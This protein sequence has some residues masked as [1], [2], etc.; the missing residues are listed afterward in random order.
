[1]FKTFFYTLLDQKHSF[2]YLK[3]IEIYLTF[4]KTQKKSKN[5]D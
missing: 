1:M 4:I 5:K 3:K 2:L